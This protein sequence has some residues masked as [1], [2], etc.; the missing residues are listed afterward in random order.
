MINYMEVEINSN[1]DIEI[2]NCIKTI[3]TTIKGSVP[4]DRD[5]GIDVGVLDQNINV[6]KGMYMIDVV[7]QIKKYEP[8]VSVK[9][10]QFKVEGAKLIPRVV[11]I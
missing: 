4:F 2:I 9:K 6:A 8:R 3:L 1:V 7:N 11:I 5:F 10:V